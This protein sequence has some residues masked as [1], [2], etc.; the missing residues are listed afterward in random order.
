MNRSFPFFLLIL[1]LACPEPAAAQN[2]T[3]RGKVR[4]VSGGTITGV[5]VE[6]WQSGARTGQTVTNNDGD[7]HFPNVTPANYEVTVNHPG[8]EPAAERVVLTGAQSEGRLEI[9]NVEV[10]LRPLTNPAATGLPGVVF[11]QNVPFNARLAYETAL[12]RLKANQTNEALAKLKEAINF[13]PDYFNAHFL[14]ATEFTKQKRTQEALDALEHARRVNDRDARVYH[15]F[16]ILMARQRKFVIAEFAFREALERDP[17]NAQTYHSHAVALIE[18]SL[19]ETDARQRRKFLG[20][21][22]RDLNRALELSGGKMA[23]AH[24]QLARIH[25][26]RGEKRLAVRDLEAYLKSQ[27]DAR[28]A[29][30]VREAIAKLKR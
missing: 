30:D 13:F 14:L 26:L 21:A 1:F 23:A 9:V 3:V 7:I 18:M 19:N 12:K 11:A 6:L 8:F 5:I 15:L 25:E 20:D 22:E 4:T 16:G 29:A 2:G 28:N 27:P 10:R 17:T 24:L